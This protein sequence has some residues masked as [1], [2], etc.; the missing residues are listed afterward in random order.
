MIEI[1]A[2]LHRAAE[3]AIDRN[4]VDE[5]QAIVDAY[6][7]TWIGVGGGPSAQGT[8]AP[9][10]SHALSQ[11]S[12]YLREEIGYAAHAERFDCAR[13]AISAIYSILLK[14]ARFELSGIDEALDL[15]VGAAAAS[16]VGA[17]EAHAA[18]WEYSTFR[19]FELAK[20]KGYSATDPQPTNVAR[21]EQAIQFL[22]IL[23][24]RLDRLLLSLVNLG[25]WQRAAEVDAAWDDAVPEWRRQ[26]W[27]DPV[28]RLNRERLATR[29]M[30]A[31]RVRLA[32]PSAS[33]ADSVLA[34][35][36]DDF[37]APSD[38]ADSLREVQRLRT[39]TPQWFAGWTAE[40][41]NGWTE[42][43]PPTVALTAAW[44]VFQHGEAYATGLIRAGTTAPLRQ[45]VAQALL[46]QL[47]IVLG[48]T[49]TPEEAEAAMAAAQAL[50]ST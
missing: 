38:L 35:V 4:S 31:H 40:P 1:L 37:P 50:L 39:Q 28:V 43:A 10:R 23:F 41:V 25:A 30:F 36:G 32:L 34:R 29:F 49:P 16:A 26:V 44:L 6:R 2:N 17:T 9:T 15:M 3:D 46:D 45:S 11:I 24:P 22:T 5:Y 20:V 47:A 21:V 14:A 8:I 7:D 19:I 13:S 12:K 33:L 48:H 18:L 27:S 42:D